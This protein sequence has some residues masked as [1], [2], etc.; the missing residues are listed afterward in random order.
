[1]NHFWPHHAWRNRLGFLFFGIAAGLSGLAA[2]EHPTLLAVL[3]ALHNALPGSDV[4]T[5]L[6]NS[7]L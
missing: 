6:P 5:P 4:L 7:A 3:V 1:M 2:W